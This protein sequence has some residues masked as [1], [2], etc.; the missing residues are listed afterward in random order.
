MPSVPIGVQ[1]AAA[2]RC[3]RD[4]NLF[5]N[6][7][8][9]CQTLRRPPDTRVHGGLGADLLK[10][11]LEDADLRALTPPPSAIMASL[12]K[13]LNDR[14]RIH[15][16]RRHGISSRSILPTINVRISASAMVATRAANT[17]GIT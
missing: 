16:F 3:T 1:T 5:K 13:L 14:S 8:K 9:T 12:R 10:S 2:V 7:A 15:R 4:R 6:R 17:F 11:S